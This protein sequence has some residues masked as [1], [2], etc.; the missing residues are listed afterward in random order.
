MT[1]DTIA[2]NVNIGGASGGGIFVAS[3]QTATLANNIV[4]NNTDK[5]NDGPDIFGAFSAS[6]CLIRSTTGATITGSSNIVNEDP[7]LAPLGNYGGTLETMALLMGSPAIDA[8]TSRGAPT[9][10]ERGVSRP[11]GSGFDIGA[12][13]SQG[14]ELTIV[15]GNNQSASPNATFTQSLVVQVVDRGLDAELF[16]CRKRGCCVYG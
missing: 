16:E 8:G 11:Q 2:I 13:E 7:L 1:N 3:T 15:S 10:D 6:N 5:T 4:A 12:F 14:F 9:T